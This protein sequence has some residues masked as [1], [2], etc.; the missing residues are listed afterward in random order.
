MILKWLDYLHSP[1]LCF[2]RFCICL[3]DINYRAKLC[4]PREPEPIFWA[5]SLAT[6]THDTSTPSPP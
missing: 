6:L 1:I 5:P 4:L 2:L 3:F